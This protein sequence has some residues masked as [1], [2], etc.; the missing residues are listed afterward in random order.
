MQRV[1]EPEVMDQEAE[2]SAYARAD[3]SDSNALFVRTAL[4]SVGTLHRAL[5]IGCGPGEIPILLAQ[6]CAGMQIVAVDASAPMLE[7]ARRKVRRHELEHRVI[8]SEQ[9]LPGLVFSRY[10]F[11][12]IYSKDTLHHIPGPQTFWAEITRLHR[13]GDRDMNVLVVDLC[14]PKSTDAARLIVE[15]VS[16]DQSPLLQK[17][18]YNSLLAAFTLE[19]IK[20]QLRTAGLDLNIAALG[21]RHFC[22]SGVLRAA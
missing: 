18:F 21:A 10:D 17:D 19:E 4:A 13:L 8:L 2:V 6:A 7:V 12:L 22:V 11:D 15:S 16:S 1:L 20:D 9:R 5:D 3:F 14:R